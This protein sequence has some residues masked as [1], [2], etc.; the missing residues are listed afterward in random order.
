MCAW[1]WQGFSWSSVDYGGNW[2]LLH[3][4]VRKLFKPV[5]VSGELLVCLPHPVAWSA[6]TPH[7][8][9]RRPTACW[10]KDGWMRLVTTHRSILHEPVPSGR[11]VC[12]RHLG[13]SAGTYDA[14]TG[15]L[16]A[17]VTS[18]VPTPVTGVSFTVLH[19]SAACAHAKALRVSLCQQYFQKVRV[20]WPCRSLCS[21][22]QGCLLAMNAAR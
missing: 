19:H 4:S 1:G 8:T 16:L 15:V 6:H 10:G 13:A 12:N 3:Y 9:V 20:A 14:A 5:L 7:G 18:D 21:R 17:Y 22:W 11:Q 2:K